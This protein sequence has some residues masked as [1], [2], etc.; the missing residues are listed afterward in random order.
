MTCG[1]TNSPPKREEEAEADAD[2]E[3]EEGEKSVPSKLARI[4]ATPLAREGSHREKWDVITCTS[5]YSV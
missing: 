4:N 5:V 3:E 2:A 1:P